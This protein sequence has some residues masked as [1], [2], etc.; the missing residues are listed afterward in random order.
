METAQTMIREKDNL[1][2]ELKERL[3]DE[4]ESDMPGFDREKS[5]FR[6]YFGREPRSA[7]DSKIVSLIHSYEDRKQRH[8]PDPPD[9][10]PA[11]KEK[12][13]KLKSKLQQQSLELEKTDQ[14]L[15]AMSEENTRLRAKQSLDSSSSG[16]S[17]VL[18][19]AM[20]ILQL[21]R[22]KQ[23]PVALTK[24]QQV[25]RALPGLETFIKSVSAEVLN[26]DA[27]AQ[28]IESV[29]PTIRT[30]KQKAVMWESVQ[31][32]RRQMCHVLRIDS[33]SDFSEIVRSYSANSDAAG[34]EW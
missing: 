15:K 5:I 6:R 26:G 1:I 31:S 4:M 30:W 33:S 22:E 2:E 23:L 3:A 27:S 9:I 20:N 18:A 24:M 7:M 13:T 8:T 11:Y 12:I 21:K 19:Q 25:I 28:S 17:E 16:G 32:T 14:K 29:L 34:R 10:P